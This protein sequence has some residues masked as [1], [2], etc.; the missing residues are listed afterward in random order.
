MCFASLAKLS[1]DSNPIRVLA[2][3]MFG[4]RR[5]P[6]LL[7]LSLEK[8]QYIEHIESFAFRNPTLASLSFM[9]NN[10]PFERDRVHFDCFA[11]NPRL[12]FLQLSH[13]FFLYATDQDTKQLFEPLQNLQKLYMGSCYITGITANTF[14]GLRNLTLLYLY[15]NTISELPDH[16]I[17]SLTNLE[18]L[19]LSTNQI[20][21]IRECIFSPETRHRLTEVDFSGNPITCDCALLWFEH[22]LVSSPSVF[23]SSY[24]PYMCSNVANTSVQDFSLSPSSSVCGVTKPTGPLSP[25]LSSSSLPSPWYQ[26]CTTIAGASV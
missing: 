8:I 4:E 1:M 5:F 25:V 24:A 16:A 22:W 3:D 26:L 14:S 21:T 11:G 9:F 18:S 7:E 20:K 17:D 12:G 2:K 23:N 6:R 15:K 13:N 19:V 10:I